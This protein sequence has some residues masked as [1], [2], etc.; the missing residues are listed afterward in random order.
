[1]HSDSVIE[2]KQFFGFDSDVP[3]LTSL[4]L[5]L[6]LPLPLSLPLSVSLRSPLT[7]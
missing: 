3:S 7:S 2:H 5:P 4:P 1:M 6:P